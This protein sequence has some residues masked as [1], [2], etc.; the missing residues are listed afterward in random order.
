MI[1]C[2]TANSWFEGYWWWVCPAGQPT[3]P[4]KFALWQIYGLGEGNLIPGSV[5]TS[6]TLTAGQW[7]YIPLPEPL[8]LSIGNVSGS[9]AAVYQV[10]TGFTGSFPDTNNQ[11]GAGQPF[12]AGITSGP[13][14]AYSDLDT[15]T[16]SPTGS[17]QG[18][19]GVASADPSVNMPTQGS[20]SSNFWIDFQ[21]SDTAPSGYTG[22]YRLWPNYPLLFPPN[23]ST[24]S[25]ADTAAQ[26]LGTQF[27]LSE[28]CA[29]NNV[30]FY[31]P[32]YAVDLPAS[33]Q[34]WDVATQTLVSG[35][36]LTAAWTGK[37][38]SGW[39]ANSYAGQNIVL[40]AGKYIATIYYGGGNY[41]YT[42]AR[43]YFG[44]YRTNAGPASANGI[45]N[46]PLSTPS[47][48]NAFSPPGGNSCFYTGGTVP[49]YPDTFDSNDG[50]ENRWVDVEVTPSA[51]SPS[52]TPSPTLSASPPVITNGSGFLTFFP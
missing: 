18:G 29:L 23:P 31:S 28:P 41:F 20:N 34:I 9:G 49:T 45:T 3:A 15:T 50:G 5:V 43:G 8:Q 2:L 17:F 22:S 40:P 7:N 38:A 11:F 10:A 4:Q 12:A 51:V 35:T 19:F 24:V 42:E 30:W 21:V 39:V 16:A 13:I 44:T 32:A 33:T 27:A 25:V 14:F 26:T 47:Q 52:P 6:G 1:F 36:N 48:A 37:V 46:G